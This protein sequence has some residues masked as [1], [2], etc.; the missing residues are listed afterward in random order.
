MGGGGGEGDGGRGGEGRRGG[1]RGGDGEDA[2]NTE[3]MSWV[4]KRLGVFSSTRN[5]GEKYAMF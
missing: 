2:G 3:P 1:G 4:F 5:I